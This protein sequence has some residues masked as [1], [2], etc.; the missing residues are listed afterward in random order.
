MKSLTKRNV[1]IYE[2]YDICKYAYTHGIDYL[3]FEVNENDILIKAESFNDFRKF[4]L[5]EHYKVCKNYVPPGTL[6]QIK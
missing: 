6:I 5:D 1:R 4:E 2:I 3:A